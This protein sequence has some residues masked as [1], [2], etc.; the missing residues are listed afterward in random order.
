MDHWPW[1]SQYQRPY[2]CDRAF[3]SRPEQAINRRSDHVQVAKRQPDTTSADQ[4]Q[5]L[6]PQLDSDIDL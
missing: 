1:C 5:P 4:Q 6:S 3:W 2:S